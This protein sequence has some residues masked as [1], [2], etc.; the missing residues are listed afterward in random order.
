MFITKKVLNYTSPKIALSA[1]I[2]E[3]SVITAAQICGG[4]MAENPEGNHSHTPL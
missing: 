4:A 1:L 2:E 3:L